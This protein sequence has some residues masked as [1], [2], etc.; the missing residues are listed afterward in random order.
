MDPYSLDYTRHSQYQLYNTARIAPG[1]EA[2]SSRAASTNDVYG[3]ENSA[4]SSSWTGT[5]PVQER[6]A[7]KLDRPWEH[8]NDIKGSSQAQAPARQPLC[9]NS[10]NSHRS[11]AYFLALALRPK[12]EAGLAWLVSE[13]DPLNSMLLSTDV[14]RRGKNRCEWDP[15]GK[16]TSC[17]R[18]LMNGT[19]CVFEKPAEK[20]QRERG[21]IALRCPTF[22]MKLKSRLIP[23]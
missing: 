9:S 14:G 16:E 12:E 20:A 23:K 15:A 6:P 18:C 13:P 2:S 4:Y 7:R 10:N 19:Q 22:Q 3:R 21:R 8:G 17:R 5:S 1:L 11:R